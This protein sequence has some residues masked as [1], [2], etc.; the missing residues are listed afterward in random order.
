VEDDGLGPDGGVEAGGVGV[1]E[2]GGDPVRAWTQVG[3]V[4]DLLVAEVVAERRAVERGEAMSGYLAG[5]ARNSRRSG[6]VETR[7][8]ACRSDSFA[9]T[10]GP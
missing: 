2:L 1:A 9:P 10:A 4:G 3:R 7:V 8:F 5:V 6:L